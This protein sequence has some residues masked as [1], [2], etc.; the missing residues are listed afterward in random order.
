MPTPHLI[1]RLQ[2]DT[3][4]EIKSRPGRSR[5]LPDDLLR[6]ASRRLGIMA[7][8]AAALWI[9]APTFGHLAFRATNPGNPD[10]ARLHVNDAVAAA[11]CAVSL[12]LYF[13]LRAREW[14]PRF[15]ITLSLWYLV[16]SGFGIGVVMH[17]TPMVRGTLD[18][19]PT[20]TWIGPVMLIFAAI[21]PVPPWKML[22][23][24][25]LAASMDPLGM[26]I[27]KAA[28]RFEYG[29]LS[30]VLVMHYAN[31]LL[32]GVAVAISHVVIR[33]GQQ[34][35]KE[36][37]LGSYHLGELLGRGGMGEVYR[38]THR[39]L[40]RPAAIKLIRA[41]VLADGDRE[42]GQLATARFRRE[43]QAAANLR[44]PHTVE[45]YDFGV[46]QDERLYFVME[47]LEG[48]DL[49]SLV[50]QHG[51]VPDRRVVHIL[52]QVCESLAEA[53]AGGLV[54]RDIKPANIHL[55]RVGLRYDF[56]K[57]LDFGLV[58]SVAGGSDDHSLATTGGHTPGT[59]AY[60]APEMALGESVDGRADIY[61][62]GCVAYYLLT[63]QRVFEAD[64]AF[65]LIA[66][67]MQQ[68][69]VPPSRR[70]GVSVEPPLERL[71]LACLAKSREARP[72]SA[73]ELERMLG[74]LG[75][76]AWTEEEARQWWAGVQQPL[77]HQAQA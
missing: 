41:E 21:V 11:G 49:E 7:L 52:R 44:S 73:G 75:M 13:Y 19:Q 9:L 6:Q 71:V 2:K 31:Y 14:D 22:I 74:E 5:Q 48:M 64:T 38:A 67:H 46:T 18:V 12:G 56:V 59:P 51:P 17:S 55:G 4:G 77:Q 65:Q 54:H 37:E 26:V 66:K 62:L 61:A 10:W 63:G 30:N 36:R 50:S 3:S 32:L 15:V 29:P 76:P 57:V 42:T 53:H 16:I 28:G 1:G 58:K 34:V 47:F 69:P 25:F 68:E 27:W 23:A 43:A 20:I 33:L 70:S 60:M 40:A 24:G 72:Q 35:A 39:M 45:L 8:I